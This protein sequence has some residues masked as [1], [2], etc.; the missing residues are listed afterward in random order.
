MINVLPQQPGLTVGGVIYKYTAEKNATDDFKVH[1]QNENAL[2]DGYIFRETDDWSQLPG[3]TI[4]KV[5]PVDNIPAE[6]WGQGSIATEGV[7]N[8]SGAS[9]QYAYRFDECYIVLNNPDCPG[10]ED[11]LYDW[12]KDGGYLDGKEINPDDPYY[13]EWVQ[14]QLNIEAEQ[15]DDTEVKEEEKSEEIEVLNGDASI[16]KLTDASSTAMYAELSS[17]VTIIEY[18]QMDIDGGIY[19]DTVVLQDNTLPTN[20]RALNNLAQ[21]QLHRQMVRSQ[22]N[23]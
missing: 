8:V 4:L 3:M 16:E 20:R 22:Y 5:V 17:S 23:E 19:K 9:V 1:V 2:G 21:Q 15:E 12:L 18:Q 14:A 11:Y 6:Y 7:G 13:D 10:Y